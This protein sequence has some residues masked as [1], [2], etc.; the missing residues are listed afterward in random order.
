[1][2]DSR[3]KGCRGERELA[4][5]LA[6]IFGVEVRR[7]QQYAGGTDTPD[8][9]GLPERI[10]PECKRVEKLNLQAAMEQAI[11]DGGP[12]KL[13]VVFHKRNRGDWMVTVLLADWLDVSLTVSKEMG[14]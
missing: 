7:G 10:H 5:E 8:V 9:V 4:R 13:P 11:K 6:D 3:A 14:Q 1:M 2:T 12:G